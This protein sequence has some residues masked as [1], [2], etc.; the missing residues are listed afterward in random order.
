MRTTGICDTAGGA[1]APFH[2]LSGKPFIYGHKKLYRRSHRPIPNRERVLPP[3]VESMKL[4]MMKLRF[5]FRELEWKL[6]VQKC[7]VVHKR[8]RFILTRI[9]YRVYIL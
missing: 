3:R 9:Y 6:I 5:P 2:F 7:T 4:L 8:S 1:D